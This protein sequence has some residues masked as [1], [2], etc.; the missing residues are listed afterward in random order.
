MQMPENAAHNIL[1]GGGGVGTNCR[2]PPFLNAPN[3]YGQLANANVLA[4]SNQMLT[5]PS[6]M[7]GAGEIACGGGGNVGGGQTENGTDEQIRKNSSGTNQAGGN[8]LCANTAFLSMAD[9]QQKQR[10]SNSTMAMMIGGGEEG[11]D[12]RGTDG[13]GENAALMM[14]RMA[15]MENAHNNNNNDSS[16]S[17][18]AANCAKKLS[19]NAISQQ[20]Q[21][22][23]AT[24]ARIERMGMAMGRKHI[25]VIIGN[26]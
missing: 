18:A 12:G 7:N 20:L 24:M 11:V 10:L 15:M 25:F 3:M 16:K 2:P 21:E 6:P 19:V 4:A 8:E 23:C 17:N 26:G 14:R 1:G 5:N 9:N 13:E 22:R